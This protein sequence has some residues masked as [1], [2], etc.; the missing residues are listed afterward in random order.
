MKKNQKS[1][2][3]LSLTF[4]NQIQP[5]YL[6]LATKEVNHRECRASA[7]DNVVSFDAK[8]AAKAKFISSVLKDVRQNMV[9][10]SDR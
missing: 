6:A 9:I 10:V 7:R 1:H 5:E 3:Q 8:E 4:N 2:K